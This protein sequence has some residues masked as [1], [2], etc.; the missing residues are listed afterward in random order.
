MV[1][2]TH[3]HFDHAELAH[4]FPEAR[5]IINRDARRDVLS[6]SRTPE[7]TA[8]W[9][10]SPRIETFTD[11]FIIDEGFIMEKVGG[12]APG[13]SVIRFKEEKII[14]AGDEAYL[15]ANWEGPRFNGSVVDSEA[16]RRFLLTL[17]REAANLTVLT[18]HDPSLVPH[19]PGQRRLFPRQ[20]ND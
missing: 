19:N 17:S 8:F 4:R 18:M 6:R 1:L 11:R 3:G 14:L 12:H 2:I 15:P 10:S 7:Q 9:S 16:N 13:S 5:V 20:K